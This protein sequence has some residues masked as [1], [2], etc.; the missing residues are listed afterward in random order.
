[1]DS[2]LDLLQELRETAQ[3]SS[4][5]QPAASPVRTHG[6]RPGLDAVW[7]KLEQPAE[8]D[9]EDNRR[10]RRSIQLDG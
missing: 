3:L 1:M 4:A 6:K 10:S 5:R 2:Y 8:S 9:S 7:Q